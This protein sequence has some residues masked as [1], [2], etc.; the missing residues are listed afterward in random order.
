M[1][2][3]THSRSV[4]PEDSPGRGPLTPLSPNG[5]PLILPPRQKRSREK[6]ERLLDAGEKL[7]SEKGYDGARVADITR[8]ARCPTG[9]FYQR[10][11]D[12]DI[13]FRAI[14]TRFLG[15]MRENADADL[16]NYRGLSP[17]GVMERL[18]DRVVS[19]MRLH[20]GLF[21]AVVERSGAH[22][23]Y[24]VLVQGMAAHLRQN[25]VSILGGAERPD[26]NHPDPSFAVAAGLQFMF[27]TLQNILRNNPGP[28]GMH[29]PR[30]VPELTRM[31]ES[32]WGLPKE[33][34]KASSESEEER[35]K[36]RGNNS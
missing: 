26:V 22:P 33:N 23:D 3:T 21:R 25:M 2:E 11:P 24:R 34:A 28:L 32:Y 5:I 10:F 31:L 17:R 1:S 6:I 15:R 13:F 29:D 18:V 20:E 4:R 9:T 8:A 27:A 16:V 36:A 12:K 7:I 30:L 14:L 35:A 19:T